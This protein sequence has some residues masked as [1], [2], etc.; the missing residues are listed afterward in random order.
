MNEV[1]PKFDNYWMIC[2]EHHFFD[3]PRS[4]VDAQMD[5]ER[6]GANLM[7]VHNKAEQK[8]L[9]EFLLE[10][11][12][13]AWLGGKRD[14]DDGTFG[15]TDGSSFKR[16]PKWGPGQPDRRSRYNCITSE[17]KYNGRWGTA[18]CESRLPYI[19]R[20]LVQP[21]PS[22]CNRYVRRIFKKRNRNRD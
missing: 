17:S 14:R 18:T 6:L 19:C 8:F 22:Q 2:Y 15:W 10:P 7:S 13:R 3:V 12:S 20:R 11:G 9:A 4:F 16:Y 1:R 5:C 21:T